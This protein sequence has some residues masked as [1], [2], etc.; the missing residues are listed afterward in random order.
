MSIVV[1]RL[2]SFLIVRAWRTASHTSPG[3]IKTSQKLVVQI[4]YCVVGSKI[5]SLGMRTVL[6]VDADAFVNCLV[7]LGRRKTFPFHI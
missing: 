4:I 2:I 7:T 1:A 5:F 3:R 6:L